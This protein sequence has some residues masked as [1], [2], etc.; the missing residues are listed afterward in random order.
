MRA[1]LQFLKHHKRSSNKVI[2]LASNCVDLVN[3]MYT[4]WKNASSYWFASFPEKQC[5]I[6]HGLFFFLDNVFEFGA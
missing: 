1:I 5:R 2:E 6:N 4:V 3:R